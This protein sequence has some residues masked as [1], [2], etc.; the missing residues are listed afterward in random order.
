MTIFLRPS[1]SKAGGMT[2]PVFNAE[3]RI[4]D[5]HRDHPRLAMYLRDLLRNAPRLDVR[6]EEIEA[7][8]DT[9]IDGW[10]RV[11]WVVENLACF[12]AAEH[13]MNWGAGY[14]SDDGFDYLTAAIDNATF[15][16]D[17]DLTEE[18]F[19]AWWYADPHDMGACDGDIRFYLFP[20][21]TYE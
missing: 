15:L 1:T 18:A 20:E 13:L 14:R 4:N 7:I 17:I 2:I 16:T 10:S 6:W 11:R 12:I 9:H 21:R 5:F 3:V 8:E 19:R